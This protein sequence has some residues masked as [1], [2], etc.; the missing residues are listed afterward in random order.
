MTRVELIRA[1]E[2]DPLVRQFLQEHEHLHVL[3][4]RKEFA[5]AFRKVDRDGSILSAAETT[6]EL[7]SNA[8]TYGVP[9]ARKFRG[10]DVPKKGLGHRVSESELLE[11][12][13]QQMALKE[14]SKLEEREMKLEEEKR[15]IEHISMELDFDA[16]AKQMEAFAK[17]DN[18][19]Q[20][21]ER[22]RFLAKMKK[23]KE[24][25]DVEGL[26]AQHSQHLRAT[27]LPSLGG[28]TSVNQLDSARSGFG[29]AAVGFDSRK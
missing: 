9:V 23:L 4:K 16:H 14:T 8:D 11:S 28:S 2:K 1:I 18:M 12:L 13:R 7:G 27:K 21:W 22:E 5:G 26:R 3:L 19:L 24:I 25:G 29:A 10:L 17:K 15:Y 6:K 20:A